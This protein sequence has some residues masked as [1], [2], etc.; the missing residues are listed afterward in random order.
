MTVGKQR[1]KAP[2]NPRINEVTDMFP[3]EGE[4]AEGGFGDARLDR[5]FKTL[6]D[7]LF[8]RIGGSIPFAC[9]DWAATKAFDYPQLQSEK[10]VS[11]ENWLCKVKSIC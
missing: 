8:R 2:E 10:I 7:S 5:R 4:T 9:Q 11:L 1:G 3:M 6:L